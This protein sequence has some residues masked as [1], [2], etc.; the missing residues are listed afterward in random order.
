MNENRFRV[1]VPY[2]HNKPH[3]RW[4][5]YPGS[6]QPFYTRGQAINLLKTFFRR[7][8][9]EEGDERECWAESD[10]ERFTLHF[11]VNLL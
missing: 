8:P 11:P 6:G 7:A 10:D 4:I 9:W 1:I 5:T 2:Y 3:S